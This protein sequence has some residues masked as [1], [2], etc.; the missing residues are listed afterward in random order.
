MTIWFSKKTNKE[1]TYRSKSISINFLPQHWKSVRWKSNGSVKG[2]KEDTCYDLNIN[3]LGIFFSYTNW[4]Y[5][6]NL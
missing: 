1:H 5:N 3:F 2:R 6:S 4:D